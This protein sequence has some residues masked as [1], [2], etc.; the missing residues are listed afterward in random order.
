MKKKILFISSGFGVGG[1]EKNLVWLINSLST[2]NYDVEIYLYNNSLIKYPINEN[3]IITIERKKYINSFLKRLQELKRVRNYIIKSNPDLVL[4]FL[5]NPNIYSIFGVMF[6]NIPVII[7]ERGDPKR[8]ALI[9][10]FKF[11]FYKKSD[12]IVIQVDAFKNQYFRRFQPFISVIP[13][14]LP[15]KNLIY[16]EKFD[17]RSNVIV[18]LA[19]IEFKQ[20]KQDYLLNVFSRFMENNLDFKLVFIGDGPDKQKLIEQVEKYG[21][22]NHVEILGEVLNPLEI[23]KNYKIFCLSS[24]FEGL[25]NALMEAMS[26]GLTVVSTDCS[27]GGCL[28][29]IEDGINGLIVPRDNPQLLLEALKRVANDQV[30][31]DKLSLN[32]LKIRDLFDEKIILTKWDYLIRSVINNAR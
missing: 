18:N 30:L 2:L 5:T 29:L 20:K 23:I 22:S 7:S 26:I 10:K 25:P 27:P 28:E 21:L 15:T 6:T 24:E 1:A 9:D 4:S 12:S 14:A 17:R 8:A 32:A 31:S 11:L 3:V 13:N 19:R 16:S